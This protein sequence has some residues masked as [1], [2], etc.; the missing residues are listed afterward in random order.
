M[1]VLSLTHALP[2]FPLSAIEEPFVNTPKSFVVILDAC[3]KEMLIAQGPHN[4]KQN[5]CNPQI[6]MDFVRQIYLEY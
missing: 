3:N 6:C 5:V 1:M 4:K 2:S